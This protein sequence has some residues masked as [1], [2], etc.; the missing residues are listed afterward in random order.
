MHY[1]NTLRYTH[2]HT[3]TNRKGNVEK[4]MEARLLVNNVKY[5]KSLHFWVFHDATIDNWN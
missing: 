1:I 5:F 3:H 2:T 4:V